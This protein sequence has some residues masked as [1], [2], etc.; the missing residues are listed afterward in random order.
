MLTPKCPNKHGKP[1]NGR[2]GYRGHSSIPTIPEIE[3][4]LNTNPHTN[5]SFNIISKEISTQ[6]DSHLD[7][8]HKRKLYTL[9]FSDQKYSLIR[10]PS[11]KIMKCRQRF[12]TRYHFRKLLESTIIHGSDDRPFA[13][14]KVFDD[15]LIGCLTQELMSPF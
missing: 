2:T 14:V 8:L 5:Q 15:I 11:L 6:T 9:D 1:E 4:N 7:T 3:I 10:Q 12:K 13:K